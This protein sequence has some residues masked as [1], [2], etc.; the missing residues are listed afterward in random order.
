VTLLDRVRPALSGAAHRVADAF[1]R[2]WFPEAE[3]ADDQYQRVVMAREVG[4]Y[5]E[6]LDPPSRTAV[7]ISGQSHADRGWK[8]YD[9]LNYPEF[10]LCAP[11]DQPRRWNVVI[12]E[13][14]L[15][16]V[17][18]PFEAARNLN[19][20]CSPGGRIIV[21]SPFLI[22]QHELPM[23]GMKDYWRFTPRGLQLML[24]DAGFVIDQVH[25]WGNRQGVLGNLGPWSSF[26]RWHSLRNDPEIAVQIW[27][28]G[29]NPRDPA[30]EPG[31]V[32]T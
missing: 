20:L 14:V 15:E 23:F 10:D 7:E 1:E 32:A 29:R 2:R 19:K 12:C 16:H 26:R 11:V 4:R 24:E 22:K 8:R 31:D 28:F 18:D 9:S 27:A 25:T 5:I 17:V 30:P 6:S 3:G 21:T 13:Q